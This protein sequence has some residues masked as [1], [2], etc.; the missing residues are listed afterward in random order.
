MINSVSWKNIWRNKLRSIVILVAMTLGLT[1]GVFL[2]AFYK[3]M[4]EQRI[5]AAID[6]ESSHIQVHPKGYLENNEMANFIADAD[7]TVDQIMEVEH[8]LA[9]SPRLII[10]SMVSSSETGAG[11]RIM[12]VDPGREKQ[13]TNLYTKIIDGTYFEGVKRN[14]IVIGQKLAEK[15]KVKVRSKIVL[16]VQEL[17]GTLSGEPF[18]VAGIYKTSNSMYDESKVFVRRSDLADLVKMDLSSAHEIAIY[19]DSN[20]ELEKVKENIGV[21]FSN[22]DVKTWTE[23]MPEVALIK[24]SQNLMMYMTII[25]ILLAMGFSIVNTMLMSVLERV[26]ELGMLMAIGMNRLRVFAMIMLETI[27]LSL[28]GGILGIVLGTAISVYFGKRGIDLSIW[29]DGLEA[30]G[31]DTVI[32]PMIDI[33]DAITVAVLIVLT[34]IV[35]AL[36]PAYKALKLNPSEALRIDN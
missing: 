3:G 1:A 8:V 9:A 4:V 21:R 29:G 20:D 36:Y 27:Y 2:L 7:M 22:S 18:R 23:L 12:G 35:A 34:G 19:I 16:T 30:I 33:K 5:A 32:Y 28:V 24:Q 6:T 14:P 15:L 26:K 13:V 10:N 25:I 11:V 31:Y 17:D